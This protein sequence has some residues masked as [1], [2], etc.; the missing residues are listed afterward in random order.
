M[1]MTTAEWRRVLG[2]NI[3]GAFYALR[4]A[5]RHMVG[6]PATAR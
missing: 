1:E 3:D 5:A 4:A 6:R 2:V